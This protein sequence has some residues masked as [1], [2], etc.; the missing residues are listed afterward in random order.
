MENKLSFMMFRA[1]I[2]QV[3]DEV[4]TTKLCIKWLQSF[5]GWLPD[6][7]DLQYCLTRLSSILP[8][9][10]TNYANCKF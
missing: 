8:K 5:S 7:G 6:T 4:E 2:A 10:D 1:E 9:K 3:T